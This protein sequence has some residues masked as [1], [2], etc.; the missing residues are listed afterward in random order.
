[1][2]GAAAVGAFGTAAAVTEGTRAINQAIKVVTGKID[3]G[4]VIKYLAYFIIICGIFIWSINGLRGIAISMN[5]IGCGLG[6]TG[7]DWPLIG[8]GCQDCSPENMAHFDWLW[9]MEWSARCLFYIAT[10]YVVGIIIYIWAK[11][12]F[13]KLLRV[14]RYIREIE[15]WIFGFTWTGRAEREFE[16][17]L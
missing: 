7:C 5:M 15:D 2:G 16:T 14:D 10:A 11:W 8:G 17:Q 6:N 4:Q 12:L 1:V 9:E 13:D 3:A